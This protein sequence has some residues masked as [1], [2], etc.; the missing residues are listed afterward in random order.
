MEG[1]KVT[2][3]WHLEVTPTGKDDFEEKVGIFDLE[4][5]APLINVVLYQAS[6]R[7]LRVINFVDN[8]G[9]ACSY[10]KADCKKKRVCAI[11][12]EC[13]AISRQID[14]RRAEPIEKD[15]IRTL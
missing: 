10:I 9:A 8:V 12:R 2:S 14:L 15:S 7:G 5:L 6:L 11:I 3:G 1:G 13:F 4:S